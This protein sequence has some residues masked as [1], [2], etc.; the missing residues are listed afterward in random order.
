MGDIMFECLA[1]LSF[2]LCS[3]FLAILI[4]T[5]DAVENGPKSD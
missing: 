4:R 1:V 5:W 2:V 3:G